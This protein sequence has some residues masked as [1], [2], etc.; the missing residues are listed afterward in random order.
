MSVV[1]SPPPQLRHFQY[2]FT[3][4]EEFGAALSG[5][6]LTA[7]FLAPQRSPTGIE[8]FQTPGW[9]FDSYDAHVKA[10]L[11]GPIPAGWASIGLM[12]S[13][14]ES[15]WHGLPVAQGMLVWH[16]PGEAIDGCILP[17]FQC[18]ALNVPLAVWEQSR[19]LAGID[20]DS[21]S[22]VAALHLRPHLYTEIERE[23]GEI[24]QMLRR[25]R[26]PQMMTTACRKAAQ[27]ATHLFTLAWE[28]SSHTAPP[29]D[30]LRNRARLARRAEEWMRAHLSEPAHVLDVCQALGVSRREL[31]YA[32]RHVF[33]QS[34]RDFLDALRLNA[35]RHALPG[36][37]SVSLVALDHGI[38]HL[39]RFSAH[40]HALFG[41]YPSQTR[42][43]VA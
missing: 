18:S 11:R 35:I 8:Q 30:S 23:L 27:F 14:V 22:K 3:D 21:A 33:D 24:R 9:T 10:R 40:Y 37:E 38:T 15:T 25:A 26:S 2:S 16:P 6:Q 17:G 34:P 31:E 32:F 4:P 13:P 19:A 29:R 42:G 5:A 12:R 20:H 7:E 43:V 1:V 41:E 39:G 28:L 36:S